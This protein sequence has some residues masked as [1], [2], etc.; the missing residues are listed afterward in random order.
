MSYTA[1]ELKGAGHLLKNQMLGG[2]TYTFTLYRP[3]NQTGKS[4]NLSGSGYFTFE[5]VRDSNGFYPASTGRYASGT[6]TAISGS[7]TLISSPYIFSYELNTNSNTPMT[8]SF[9][10]IPDV[11]V[12]ISGAYLRATGD[13][14]M[15]ISPETEAC[16]IAQNYTTGT[17]NYPTALESVLGSGTGTV[18][19]TPQPFGI[20][21]R[22]IVSWDGGIVIETGYISTNP[23][24]YNVGGGQRNAFQQALQGRTAPEGGT[25]PLTPGGTAPNVIASDGYPVIN[26]IGTYNFNKN[27]TASTADVDVYGPMPNTGWFSTLSCPV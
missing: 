27:N 20:P 12:P 17:Q 2:G 4:E 18:T 16:N 19:L 5:T 1:D 10:F 14:D 21:D 25:Y 26:A 15:Y 9:E 22:W 7:N 13:Y 23:A 6:K 3:K 24:L 8:S 11:D